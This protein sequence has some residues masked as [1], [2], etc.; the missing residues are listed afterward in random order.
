MKQGLGK[1]KKRGMQ[2]AV[3]FAVFALVSMAMPT[4]QADDADGRTDD[5]YGRLYWERSGQ[6]PVTIQFDAEDNLWSLPNSN[7]AVGEEENKGEIRFGSQKVYAKSSNGDRGQCGR[8][9]LVARASVANRKAGDLEITVEIQTTLFVPEWA[10]YQYDPDGLDL[11]YYSSY[12]S[13][14]VSTN[15]DRTY[16]IGGNNVAASDGENELAD[17]W[18]A[19]HNYALGKKLPISEI[20]LARKGLD[21]FTDDERPPFKEPEDRIAIRTGV[22]Y[23]KDSDDEVYEGKFMTFYEELL[24]TMPEDVGDKSEL[25]IYVSGNPSCSKTYLNPWNNDGIPK[26]G[27]DKVAKW[28]INIEQLRDVKD[29][30]G[31]GPSPPGGPGGVYPTS[32]PGD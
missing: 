9:N 28:T 25:E 24:V 2:I 20:K 15:N 4:S 19:A 14:K 17:F 1:M 26:S 16:D 3:I 29:G 18:K 11:L 31:G 5:Q 21:T 22:D 12:P 23:K 10:D 7:D 6:N 32:D 27:V 13:T 30:G 8:A